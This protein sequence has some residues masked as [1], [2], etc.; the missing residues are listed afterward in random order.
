WGR[1]FVHVPPCAGPPQ[2][3][4]DILGASEVRGVSQDVSP[5]PFGY[6]ILGEDRTHGTLGCTRPAAHADL[7]IDEHL[8][9]RS[10]SGHLTRQRTTSAAG[11][12]RTVDAVDWTRSHTCCVASCDAGLS[13]HVR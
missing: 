6:F 3:D 8:T 13:N 12:D 4:P 5:P 1:A 11:R 9:A 2:T 10:P 7:W